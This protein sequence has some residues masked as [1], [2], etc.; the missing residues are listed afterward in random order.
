MIELFLVDS[1]TLLKLKLAPG[2]GT[3]VSLRPASVEEGKML[4]K[5]K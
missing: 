2:G 4:K 3:A 1:K 5:Y